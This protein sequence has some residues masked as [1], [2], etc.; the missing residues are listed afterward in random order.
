M[1]RIEELEARRHHLRTSKV[2]S[3]GIGGPDMFGSRRKEIELLN[4]E[5]L[6][7][8]V[9]TLLEKLAKVDF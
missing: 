1:T 4:L 9:D 7:A 6:E 5:I 3:C 8:K 2:E